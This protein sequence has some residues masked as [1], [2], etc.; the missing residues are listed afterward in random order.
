MTDEKKYAGS[1]CESTGSTCTG[2]GSTWARTGSTCDTYICV[3]AHTDM[4]REREREAQTD[5]Y[6]CQATLKGGGAEQA[7]GLPRVVTE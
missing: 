6:F 3:R 5:T 2:L 1:T 7:F 4:E